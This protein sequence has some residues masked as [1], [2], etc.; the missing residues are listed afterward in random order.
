MNYIGKMFRKVFSAALNY[1]DVN[2]IALS[3]PFDTLSV[4][5][6]LVYDSKLG[7]WIYVTNHNTM[8]KDR[9][10]PSEITATDSK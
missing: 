6:F 7:K 1:L 10:P 8:P 2:L 5:D 3:D 9:R 4:M